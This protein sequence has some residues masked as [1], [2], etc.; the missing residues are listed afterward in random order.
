VLGTLI[1]IP[2]GQLLGMGRHPSL[3]RTWLCLLIG[4]LTACP[5]GFWQAWAV[6]SP[7]P[8]ASEKVTLRFLDLS[9]AETVAL[10]FLNPTVALHFP[11]PSA[12]QMAAA[13]FFE[14]SATVVPQNLA[15]AP[16]VN[17]PPATID[18][19]GLQVAAALPPIGHS[20]FCLRYPEDC[21]IRGDDPRRQGI[22]LTPGRWGDL[23]K[24]NRSVNRGILAEVT[25]GDGT[26]EEWI[27]SPH[28]G[29]CK[30]YAITK[31][32]ELLGRGWP[33]RSLLLSEVVLPSGEHHLILVVRVKDADLVLD[34]LNDEIRLAPMTYAQY[35]WVRI[36][37]PE[38][39]RF[40]LRVQR[41]DA[42]STAMLSN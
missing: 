8:S 23:D 34:N 7:D 14:V 24:V 31:R 39:P 41:P 36:Q 10:R 26:T 28:A 18:L 15:S 21:R 1:H 38:N 27:I 13:R 33:S 4:G 29:D 37:S 12:S 9:P 20:R 16:A 6:R 30:D 42:E 32:H 22:V 3:K 17:L 35:R 40:W 19:M 2:V 25:P 5:L 11:F